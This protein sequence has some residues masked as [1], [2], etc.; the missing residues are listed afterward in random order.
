MTYADEEDYSHIGV[1]YSSEDIDALLLPISG[2][3]IETWEPI[4]LALRDGGLVDYLANDLGARLCS[5]RLREIIET[6]RTQRDSI[7][8][9][10]VNVV[11]DS[12]EETPYHILHFPTAPPVVKKECSTYAGDMV[13]KAV[14]D[15]SVVR[16]LSIFA[17]PDE[18]GRITFV[19]SAMRNRI[20][21][22]GLTG[23]DFHPVRV[24]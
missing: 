3:P 8:W 11:S 12:G 20:L 4:R 18:G 19:S 21:L 5:A 24:V 13:V 7:Q 17:L 23:M 22:S 9:V 16:G 1:A 15:E 6:A 14:L 2:T 10:D